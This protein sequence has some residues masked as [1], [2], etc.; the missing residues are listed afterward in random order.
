MKSRT[1]LTA[2]CLAVAL[3][4]A[5]Q[6]SAILLTTSLSDAYSLGSVV[7]GVP[8]DPNSEADFVNQLIGMSLNAS[9]TLS[10]NV[11]TRSGN[12]YSPLDAAVAGPATAYGNPQGTITINVGSGYEYLAA[13][14]DGGSGG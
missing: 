7:P 13:K 10:G 2:I 1:L 4:V 3:T 11:F 14:Y 9:T 12:S 5:Q 6:A 8:A